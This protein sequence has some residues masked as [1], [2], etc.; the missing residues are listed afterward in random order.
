MANVQAEIEAL[1]AIVTG[2]SDQSFGHRIQGLVFGSKG[3]AALAA[4]GPAAFRI[5]P[6]RL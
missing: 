5:T 3:L 2:L 4:A 1:Q 6:T